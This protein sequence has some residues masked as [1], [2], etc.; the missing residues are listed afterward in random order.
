MP[1]YMGPVC[2]GLLAQITGKA[3]RTDRK[4]TAAAADA[5]EPEASDILIVTLPEADREKAYKLLDLIGA[6]YK[7]IK[8]L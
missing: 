2:V 4:A 8:D 5:A 3:S 6:K 1:A 7:A